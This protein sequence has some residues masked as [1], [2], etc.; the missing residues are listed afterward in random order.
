[1]H[2]KG[3]FFFLTALGGCFL[4]GIWFLFTTGSQV[5]VPASHASTEAALVRA[6]QEEPPPV[7]GTDRRGEDRVERSSALSV[8]TE[9]GSRLAPIAPG[10][11]RAGRK[12]AKPDRR[13]ANRSEFLRK[14]G[15]SLSGV[16][17]S[18]EQMTS[19]DQLRD[20]LGKESSST[21]QELSHEMHAIMRKMTD[22]EFEALMRRGCAKP[23]RDFAANPGRPPYGGDCRVVY[24]TRSVGGKSVSYAMWL[25]FDEY[26]SLTEPGRRY[27][28]L[29]DEIV[30]SIAGIAGTSVQQRK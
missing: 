28:Q 7:S 29:N 26:P 6:T 1:M 18:E 25:Y 3:P 9:A 2:S 16:P 24:R 15:F 21:F 20:S 19:L 27:N 14:F 4:M 13:T 23:V 5:A 8:P 12:I 10:A 11:S 30:R 22:D 17:L